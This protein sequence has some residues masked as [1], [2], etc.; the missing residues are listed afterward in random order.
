MIAIVL[1][2]AGTFVFAASANMVVRANPT[3]RVPQ[4]FGR[5]QRHPGRIYA[6][7]I[8]ALALLCASAVLLAAEVGVGAFL[9]VLLGGLPAVFLVHRHN[10]ERTEIRNH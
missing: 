8:A 1:W 7:R 10:R 9:A 6:V 4:W 3:S 2:I 5:P